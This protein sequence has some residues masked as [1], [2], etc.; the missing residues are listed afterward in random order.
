MKQ[1]SPRLEVIGPWKFQLLEDWVYFGR[2]ETFTVPR[3]FITDAASI[4]RVFWPLLPPLGPYTDGAVLHDWLLTSGVVSSWDAHRL[5]RR[6][7]RN[8]GT[9]YCTSQLMYLAVVAWNHYNLWRAQ[10]QTQ[11]STH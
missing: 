7:I 11:R 10:W 8:G 9:S 4:P 3:G 1:T 6:V 2:W 5:F